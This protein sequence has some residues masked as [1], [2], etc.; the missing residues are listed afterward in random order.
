MIFRVDVSHDDPATHPAYMC[1]RCHATMIKGRRARQE[2]HTRKTSL[3]PFEWVPHTEQECSVSLSSM[4]NNINN[5]DYSNI[6]Y[7]HTSS[8]RL[9]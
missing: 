8:S 4:N 9:D 3:V 5:Y 1:R 6:R 7:V 2:G